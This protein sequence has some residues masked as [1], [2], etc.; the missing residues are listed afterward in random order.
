MNDTQKTK[1][2]LIKE[3]AALRQRVAELKEE[4]DKR[5]ATEEALR[6]TQ[7]R[8][9]YLLVSS[10]AV[11]YNCKIEGE[12]FVPVFV[13]RNFTE[14]FGYREQEFLEDPSWWADHLHPEDRE[15]IFAHFTEELF[16]QGWYRHEYRFYHKKR[17]SYCWIRD[18]MNLICDME[19]SPEAIVGSWLD[20]TERRQAEA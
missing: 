1:A 8:L 10:P 2:Q 9:D 7:R 17:G 4:E 15:R 13:S 19:G 18:E 14:Q 20:I 5:T 11:I 3:Q 12:R 16:A 6:E